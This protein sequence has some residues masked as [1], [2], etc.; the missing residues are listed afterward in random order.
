MGY[1]LPIIMSNVGGNVEA[2]A[3]YEG[4]VLVPPAQPRALADA[5][6]RLPAMVGTRYAHPHSWADTADAYEQLFARLDG[7]AK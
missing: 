5:I 1:G 7:R 2:S 6:R 3:G 4:I